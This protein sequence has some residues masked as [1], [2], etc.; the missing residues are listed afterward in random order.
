MGCEIT[1]SSL[2]KH[3]KKA[4]EGHDG[5]GVCV[6]FLS[7]CQYWIFLV[8]TYLKQT[9][10][11]DLCRFSNKILLQILQRLSFIRNFLNYKNICCFECGVFFVVFFCKSAGL[12]SFGM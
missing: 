8:F 1:N 4:I 2:K 7:V 5:E 11:D 9:L 10:R 6:L 3:M 12:R